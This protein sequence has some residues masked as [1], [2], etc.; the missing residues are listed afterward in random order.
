MKLRFLL[1]MVGA[2]LI[3]LFLMW[4]GFN[5]IW[6]G[7]ISIHFSKDQHSYAFNSSENAGAFYF[8]ALFHIAAG[9]F[10]WLSVFAGYRLLVAKRT[11]IL[12][13][14]IASL[15]RQAPSGIRPL[16]LGL[17]VVVVAVLIYAN[18]SA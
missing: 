3:G 12:G 8:W 7:E 17:L 10:L 13:E 18:F 11:D 15:E 5:A 6:L 2:S 9:G 16:W 14:H 1:L 4:L